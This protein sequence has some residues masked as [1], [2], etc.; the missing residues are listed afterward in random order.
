MLESRLKSLMVRTKAFL[1]WALQFL[2]AMLLYVSILFV[3]ILAYDYLWPFPSIPPHVLIA[4]LALGVCCIWGAG[5]WFW[6]KVGSKRKSNSSP[7]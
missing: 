6:S 2:G 7:R 5:R 4:W 1:C 3:V